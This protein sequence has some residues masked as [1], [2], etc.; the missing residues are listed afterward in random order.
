MLLQSIRDE[1]F[2]PRRREVG[3]VQRGNG[4]EVAH[5]PGVREAE[6]GDGD[7]EDAAHDEAVVERVGRRARVVVHQFEVEHT[8]FWKA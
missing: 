1:V 4:E 7:A 5:E 2:A 8:E 3:Q 6:F